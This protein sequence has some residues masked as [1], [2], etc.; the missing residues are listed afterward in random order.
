LRHALSATGA[1]APGDVLVMTASAA[2]SQFIT[3]ALSRVF[4]QKHSSL[5]LLLAQ[6]PRRA[7]RN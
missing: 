3:A 6:Q 5:V 7:F 4:A 2:R 1:P